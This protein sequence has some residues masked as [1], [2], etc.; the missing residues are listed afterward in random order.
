M[1]V[2]VLGVGM[3]GLGMF[4]M[5]FVHDRRLKEDRVSAGLAIVFTVLAIAIAIDTVYLQSTVKRYMAAQIDCNTERLATE[6]AV[7]AQ[8]Q[9]VDRLAVD[10]DLALRQYLVT[11]AATP[12]IP[13]DDP[14]YVN[15][16]DKLKD[17]SDARLVMVQTYADHPWPAC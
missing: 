4:A 1:V 11:A 7:S 8:R 13:A 5:M 6:A 17:L 3:F 12:L 2:A 10:Y 15:V 9:K 14:A 16:Q